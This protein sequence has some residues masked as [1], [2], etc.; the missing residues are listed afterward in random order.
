MKKNLNRALSMLIALLMVLCCLPAASAEASAP[1]LAESASAL[2]AAATLDSQL[3]LLDRIANDNEAELES[4]GWDVSLNVPPAEALPDNL[5]PESY[6]GALDVDSF[7][8]ELRGRK[9]LALCEEDGEIML[10]GDFAV[11]LPEAMRPESLAQAEGVLLLREWYQKRGDYFGEAYNTHTEVYAWLFDAEPVYRLFELTTLPPYSGMGKLYGASMSMEALFNLC[12]P[13]A[14]LMKLA[15]EDGEMWFRRVGD[16]CALVRVEGDRQRLHVPD[17]VEGLPVTTVNNCSLSLKCPSL[18]SV[19]LPDSVTVIGKSAF[20]DCEKLVEINLPRSLI[21]IDGHAFR[22]CKSLSELSFPSSLRSIGTFAFFSC[23]QLKSLHFNEGLETAE[24]GI[25][26]NNSE[27]SQV[28]IPSTLSVLPGSFLSGCGKLRCV[29][30]PDGVKQINNDAL[31]C[32]EMLYAYLP[33]S[34]ETLG[35]NV[36]DENTIVYAPEG[37]AAALW[38]QENDREY[39]PCASAEEV[40]PLAF[41]RDG[42]I[43]YAL[44]GDEA[45]FLNYSGEDAEVVIPDMLGGK[46]V[47]RIGFLCFFPD[48]DDIVTS[49]TLPASVKRIAYRALNNESLTFTVPAM[50]VV[51]MDRAIEISSDALTIIAPEG[52]TAHQYALGRGCAWEPLTP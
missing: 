29:V 19:H 12:D 1:A 28:T 39:I 52:S 8:E 13:G 14:S 43:E 34:V 30:V 2:A 33:A 21:S 9:L 48:A 26:G 7:P 42:D 3:E 37:S 44:L 24:Y 38:A 35:R 20:E 47:T 31:D 40:P 22:E 5:L 49:L 15:D 45:I 23:Y 18:T 4:G 41:G 27:L 32:G 25:T 6:N 11:R 10:C 36:V 46:P 16:G 50:D 17:S 51:F